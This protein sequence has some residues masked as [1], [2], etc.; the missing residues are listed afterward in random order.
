MRYDFLIKKV[1]ALK[2]LIILFVLFTSF[3]VSAD[4][5]TT[6][7]QRLAKLTGF[8][9]QFTQI[10]KTADEQLVQ[11]GR[12]ELWLKKPNYFY[13]QMNEPDETAIISNGKDIWFYTPMV[14]QV[15]IMSLQQAVDNRLFLLITDNQS[16][17]WDEYRV[18]RKQDTFN[19]IPLTNSAQQGFIIKI[20]PTGML[21]R[22]TVIEEDGQRSIY[23]L[24]HQKLADIP[25]SQFEFTV[26]SNVTVDDQ[27]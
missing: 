8:Y 6:L 4:D 3:T 26:P 25:V 2:N 12:G 1:N 10:V 9:A 5:K 20:L 7:Q 22:F 13:W 18:E 21:S 15:V 27:R 17:I 14:E 23:D 24:S 11:E 16:D 19:L